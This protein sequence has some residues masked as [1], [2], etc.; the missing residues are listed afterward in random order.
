MMSVGAVCLNYTGLG[1]GHNIHWTKDRRDEQVII[2]EAGF[3]PKINCMMMMMN[4]RT[5]SQ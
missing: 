1:L 2:R 3:A 5:R 4:M